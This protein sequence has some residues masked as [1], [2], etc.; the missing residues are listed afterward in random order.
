METDLSYAKSQAL[1]IKR[2]ANGLKRLGEA[3]KDNSILD[4]GDHLK[5]EVGYLMDALAMEADER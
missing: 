3:R 1:V 5:T 4:Y 2:I